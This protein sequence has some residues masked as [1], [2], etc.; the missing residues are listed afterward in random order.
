MLRRLVCGLVAALALAPVAAADGSGGPSPGVVSGGPGATLPGFGLRYVALNDGSNT[1]L[2]AIQKRNGTVLDTGVL[3]GTWGVPIIGFDGSTGGLSTDRNTLVLGDANPAFGPNGVRKTSSFVVVDAKRLI[4]RARFSL[5][6]DFAFD[7]LSPDGRTL[8]L[9]Q[10]VS[11]SDLSR[12]IVRAY[13]LATTR[14]LPGRIADR[15]Q[16]GWV[17]TGY[18]VTRA[19]SADGRWVYTLYR[20]DGGYPFV[21]A[22][23]TVNRKAHCIGVPWSGPQDS[24]SFVR[25]SVRDSGGQLLIYHQ[26]GAN[27]PV[28]SIDTHTYRF[29]RAAYESGTGG[30]FPWWAVAAPVALLLALAGAVRIRLRRGKSAEVAAT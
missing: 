22:L 17:M 10:H 14:L 21:H 19:T 18:A 23:D 12:Y 28:G 24:L 5:R 20:N 11:A 8:F 3:K 7:A 13:D 26:D 2:E 16:R 15:A 6:G 9:I 29:V 4:E 27:S 25:L 1:Y 30:T